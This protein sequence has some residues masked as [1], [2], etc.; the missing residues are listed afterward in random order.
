MNLIRSYSLA[1]SGDKDQGYPTP[2]APTSICNDCNMTPR[3]LRWRGA[4]GAQSYK[5]ER[6]EQGHDVWQTLSARV[7]DNVDSGSIL[8]NDCDAESGK[9]YIYRVQSQSV[10][11]ATSNEWF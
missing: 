4:A 11:G 5:I 9:R 3:C 10:S 1:L 2:E 6:Q 8:F 7:Y